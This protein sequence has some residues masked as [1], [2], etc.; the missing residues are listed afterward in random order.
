MPYSRRAVL[1]FVWCALFAPLDATVLIP[2]EFREIVNGSDIIAS[3]RVIDTTPEWGDNRKR[4]DTRVTLQVGTYLKGGPGETV[5]F[6]VPGGEIGRFRNVMVG[7]PVF[8]TGDEVVVFL[9]RRTSEEP[10]VFG[11]NQGVFRISFD[12]QT[13]RRVVVRPAV[14]ARGESPEIVVR[15]SAARRSVP[16]ETFGAQVQAVLAEGAPRGAR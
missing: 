14:L 6:K 9:T 3:G 16:L 7:A 13:K 5:V 12:E 15:G 2:A 10:M 11:L 8:R 1:C 4:I